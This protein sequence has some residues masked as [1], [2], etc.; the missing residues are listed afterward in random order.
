MI[1]QTVEYA[2][3]SA[4]YVASRPDEPSTSLQIAEATQVPPAYLAKVLR[5]LSRA[6]IIHSQ[7]G[8]GGGYRL[9]SPASEL[10]LM[11]IVD[12]VDPLPRIRG[13][14]LGLPQHGGV[15]C[16]LHRSLDAALAAVEN[17]FRNT[18][19]ADLLGRNPGHPLCEFARPRF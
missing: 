14:P 15:L 13:C 18:T 4:V 9:A 5:S 17:S 19:L 6:G 1:S 16:P 10:T 12:A 3:R 8:L 2:L 7:R 11:R